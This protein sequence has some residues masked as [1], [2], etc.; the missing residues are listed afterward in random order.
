MALLQEPV[1]EVKIIKNYIDGE[2]VASKG[3]MVDV[4]NPATGKTIAKVPISP[5]SKPPKQPFPTG[6]ERPRWPGR[7]CSSD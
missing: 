2:W 3:E 1:R 6:G 4:V 5:L 7:D